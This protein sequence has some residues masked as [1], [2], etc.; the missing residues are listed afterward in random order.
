MGKCN[1]QPACACPEARCRVEWAKTATPEIIRA[2]ILEVAGKELGQRE[3]S[4]NWSPRIKQYLAAAKVKT[5]APW[6]AAYVNWVLQELFGAESLLEQV[7]LQAYVQSYYDFA[8]KNDLL[9][10]AVDVKPG[11]L[12]LLWF[13]SLNRYGHIGIVKEMN[14]K[15]GRYQTLEGNSNDEGSREGYEVCSNSRIVGS[16]VVFM[17]SFR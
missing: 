5:P 7:P 6:C 17:R 15:K 4:A 10:K 8:K 2:A 1:N 16:R 13:P 14:F 11:D 3:S 12:F 9:V